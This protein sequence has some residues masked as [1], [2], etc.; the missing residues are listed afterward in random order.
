L[1]ALPTTSIGLCVG[2]LTLL[3]GGKVA[4]RDGVLEFRGALAR[5]LLESPLLGASA[6]TLGHVILGRDAKSLDACRVHEHRHVRQAEVL[7]P[8]FLPA[9][10]LASVW[11]ALRHGQHYRANWFEKDAARYTALGHEDRLV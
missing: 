2:G 11:A 7:G 6:A 5:V 1:W 9:Y 3:G 4:R 8:F 10:L